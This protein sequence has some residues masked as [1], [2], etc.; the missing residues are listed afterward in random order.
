MVLDDA[1]VRNL[2]IFYSASFQGRKGSLLGTID[3]TKTAMG[4]RRLQQW[5]R[6]PL[7]DLALLE[8]RQEAVAEFVAK[9]DIRAELLGALEN[10]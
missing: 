10:N 8:L 6:Y 7:L 4:G 1:T 5:L 9:S 3:H 2:E